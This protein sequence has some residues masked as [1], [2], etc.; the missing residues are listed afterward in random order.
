MTRP[1]FFAV[2]LI[3]VI[4]GNSLLPALDKDFFPEE[5]LPALEEGAAVIR[6]FKS[7]KDL[8]VAGD[9]DHPFRE[10]LR[11]M[12]PNYLAEAFILIPGNESESGIL[13]DLLC[14]N[15]GDFTA[16]KSIPYWSARQ[17]T[18]YDLFSEATVEKHEIKGTRSSWVTRFIMNPFTSYRTST[19]I[20]REAGKLVFNSRNEDEISYAYNDMKAIKK[21]NM[22]WYIE[23]EA[24]EDGLLIYGVGAVYAF[25]MFG[26]IR[27]RLETSL[28]GRM[29]AFFSWH[30]DR[31]L[32]RS[33]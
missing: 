12:K 21:H 9:K 28:T 29:R 4:G 33:E 22:H 1:L 8:V 3:L 18:W 14:E 27:N 30:F 13:L 32:P 19:D 6:S 31:L 26:V 15:L 5:D 20:E 10:A 24:G 7:Y 17:E 25:D 16:W 11:E 23:A 2:A